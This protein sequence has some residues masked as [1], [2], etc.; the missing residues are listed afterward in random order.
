MNN[1]EL[2]LVGGEYEL[3]RVVVLFNPFSTRAKQFGNTIGELISSEICPD[4]KSYRPRVI[5]RKML[6]Y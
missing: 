1:P 5:V 2:Q 6:G 4:F 3:R